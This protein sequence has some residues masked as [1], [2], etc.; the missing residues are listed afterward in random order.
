MIAQKINPGTSLSQRESKLSYEIE[1][2]GQ[3][4]QDGA[5]TLNSHSIQKEATQIVCGLLM[6]N[7]TSGFHHLKDIL[8]LTGTQAAQAHTESEDHVA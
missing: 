3:P 8:S 6:L 1:A 5:Q 4:V 2:S 7:A